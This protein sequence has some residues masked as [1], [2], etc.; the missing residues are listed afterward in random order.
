MG[1]AR[2]VY[3]RPQDLAAK[4]A[5]VQTRGL[6]RIF[7]I[8]LGGAALAG[9]GF[10]D[11]PLI[12]FH[13]AQGSVVGADVIPIFYAVAMAVSGAGSFL[14]GRL[15]DRFGIGV[16]LP[17][18]VVSALYAPLA[19]LGGFWVALVG[20]SLWGLGMGVQ[21]SI[22]PA[23][24]A[25]MVPAARRASAYGLFTAG[26]GIA[27]FLGSVLIGILYSVAIPA[28]VAFALVAEVAALPLLLA[29]RR[30][31]RGASSAPPS[32]TGEPA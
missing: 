30:R 29:V 26:Y 25:T 23:A 6:P 1:V 28:A 24:V 11:W 32:P 22:I 9:A 21:E 15:Y 17:L 2:F 7:W 8:Y 20:A 27:W 18:T 12:A 13:F 4:P 14:F 10:A 3:P 16:L 19:F 5:D 31:T